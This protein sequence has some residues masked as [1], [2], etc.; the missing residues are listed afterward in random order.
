MVR[1]SDFP[2]QS[3]SRLQSGSATTI[4]FN[5]MI[6]RIFDWMKLTQYSMRMLHENLEIFL[7]TMEEPIDWKNFCNKYKTVR[8]VKHL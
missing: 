6:N 3:Q 8:S 1:S 2:E 5:E 4:V 7:K